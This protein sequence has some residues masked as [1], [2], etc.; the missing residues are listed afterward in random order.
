MVEALPLHQE[1]GLEITPIIVGIIH[2]QDRACFAYGGDSSAENGKSIW[3]RSRSGRLKRSNTWLL[4]TLLICLLGECR[5]LCW[6]DLLTASKIDILHPAFDAL[7][8]SACGFLVFLKVHFAH[9][10]VRIRDL[11]RLAKAYLAAKA[12]PSKYLEGVALRV[13]SRVQCRDIFRIRIIYLVVKAE[14]TP[15]FLRHRWTANYLYSEDSTLIKRIIFLVLEWANFLFATALSNH[16]LNRDGAVVDTA[17]VHA[18][19]RTTSGLSL[20]AHSPSFNFPDHVMADTPEKDE[21]PPV[22]V[23]RMAPFHNRMRL[24][25]LLQRSNYG[26]RA[27]T[28]EALQDGPEHNTPWTVIA[29]INGVEYARAVRQTQKEAKEVAA[30]AAYRTL[31]REMYN[32]SPQN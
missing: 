32:A 8:G 12:S 2:S 9:Y 16:L 7:S 19:R 14:T 27:L 1:A 4:L 5:M 6:C 3:S 29:C 20:P 13:Y 24:N 10:I 22:A 17:T 21:H 18:L 31:Y 26:P 25:N 28:W 15:N 11:I 23:E 30:A